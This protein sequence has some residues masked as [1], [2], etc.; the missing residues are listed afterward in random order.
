MPCPCQDTVR[1]TRTC[2][3]DVVVPGNASGKLLAS[4]YELSFWG[5]IDP[6]TSEVIDRQHPLKG[7][8]IKDNILAIPGGRGSCSGSGVILE[9]LLNGN[10]PQGLI[11]N[12]PEAILSLGVVVAKEIFQRS[13]PV[14]ILSEDYFSELYTESTV[15]EAVSVSIHEGLVSWDGVIRRY[16]PMRSISDMRTTPVPGAI[17]LSDLD[18]AMLGGK[19][20]EASA[21]AMRI[22]IVMSKLLEAERL[23]NVTQV[24]IDACVYTGPGCLAFAEKLRD[25]GG[26]VA[27]PTTLNSISVDYKRWRAQGV[28][29]TFGSAAEK[30]A[31]AYTDMGANP[32]FTCAPYLLESAPKCGEQVA[33]AESNAVVYANSVLGARTMKYPDFLDVAIALTGR[34]PYGGPHLANNRLATI[35]IDVADT[36]K[37]DIDDDILFAALGYVVGETAGSRIPAIHGLESRKPSKDDLKAFS[38]AFATT[39]SAPMFH[40]VGVTP[41]ATSLEAITCTAEGEERVPHYSEGMNRITACLK[42]LNSDAM[43]LR[44]P[45]TATSVEKVDLVSLG[46]PH[47]SIREM[48]RLANICQDRN[49]D[50]SVSIVVC[51]GRSTYGLATQSGL[52]AELEAFGV[53]IVEDTCWCIIGEPIISQNVKVIMTNSAKYAHYGPGLT[54]ARSLRYRNGERSFRFAGLEECMDAASLGLQERANRENCVL[55]SLIHI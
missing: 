19:F 40:I 46:N 45:E 2:D 36:P 16:G 52:I 15:Y 39:S 4:S 33:W 44:R 38:A 32:S 8:Y 27:V 24:H 22:I 25:L 29:S 37:L 12:K 28:E 49:K 55:L 30:L 7:K 23:T 54:G 31:N 5:G 43:L 50:P 1:T 26:K 9:L 20:G 10:G 13:I 51:C 53:Q 3:A 35:W 11:F 41:E 17:E 47:F 14:V 6:A 21:A 34:A 18:N 42:R 48:R